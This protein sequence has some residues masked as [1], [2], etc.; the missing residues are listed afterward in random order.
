VLPGERGEE[1]LAGPLAHEEDVVVV[2]FL[3][4]ADTD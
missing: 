1:E 3:P 2:A 4:H